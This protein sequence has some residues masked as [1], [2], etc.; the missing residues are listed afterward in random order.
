MTTGSIE[1][2]VHDLQIGLQSA[3]GGVLTGQSTL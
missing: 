2:L 3:D 1:N